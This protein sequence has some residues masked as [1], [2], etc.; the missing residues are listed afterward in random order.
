MTRV[1]RLRKG[2]RPRID[3]MLRQIV[4]YPHLPAKVVVAIMLAESCDC[5]E[6]Y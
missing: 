6:G 5:T 1:R 2:Y 4:L 3:E